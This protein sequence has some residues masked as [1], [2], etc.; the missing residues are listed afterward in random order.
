MFDW[1]ASVWSSFLID[2]LNVYQHIFSNCTL[3]S[4]VVLNLL[5]THGLPSDPYRKFK[6]ILSKEV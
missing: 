6:V 2:K 4:W 5:S 3:C 1:L